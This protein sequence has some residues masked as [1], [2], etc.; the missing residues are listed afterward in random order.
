LV[1]RR[2]SRCAT[3]GARRVISLPCQ[4]NS[5]CGIAWGNAC[6]Y[7]S[8]KVPGS[9]LGS[10]AIFLRALSVCLGSTQR[11]SRI[12]TSQARLWLSSRSVRTSPGGY[13]PVTRLAV[14]EEGDEGGNALPGARRHAA[15]L[16]ASD[17]FDTARHSG[18]GFG[19]AP[20]SAESTK[21]RAGDGRR[22]T[23]ARS[24]R[25]LPRRPR[26]R[27]CRAVPELSCPL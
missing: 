22:P 17:R 27:R 21:R 7:Q 10:G 4:F 13:F 24:E 16:R 9:R 1:E 14:S 20:T 12:V 26:R 2:R 15:P 18:R 5:R 25:L 23:L 3:L 6:V 19:P 8:R 11:T